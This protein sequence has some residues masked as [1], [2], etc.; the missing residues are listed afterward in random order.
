MNLHIREG[1]VLEC[2]LGHINGITEL[3]PLRPPEL[4][5]LGSETSKVRGRIRRHPRLSL[6][7]VLAK[8]TGHVQTKNDCIACTFLAQRGTLFRAGVEVP[9]LQ[10]LD[11]EVCCTD[12]TLALANRWWLGQG[13]RC[14]KQGPWSDA[15][16]SHGF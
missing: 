16:I 2:S 15:A 12:K 10:C 1:T 7:R 8:R 4:I 13:A 5:P 3:R 11:P 14:P 9:W 6:G